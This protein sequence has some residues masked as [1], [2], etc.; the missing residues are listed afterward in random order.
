MSASSAAL[1]KNSLVILI[2]PLTAALLGWVL[3][4]EAVTGL[5]T[6]QEG[7]VSIILLAG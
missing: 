1:R 4:G 6:T 3:L 5:F 7:V 2:Q